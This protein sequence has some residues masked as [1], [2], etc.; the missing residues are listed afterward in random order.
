[1]VKPAI[2]IAEDDESNMTYFN[3]ILKD[4][5]LTIIPAIN[6][7][8]AVECCHDHPEIS[9]VLMDMKMPVMDGMEATREIKKIRKDI[10]I[11]AV[12]AFTL[13]GD[14]KRAR[15]AGCDD[16]LSKPVDKTVLFAKLKKYG[17]RS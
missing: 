10:S 8:E 11:I 12:T 14:E 5:G 2:L 15:D 16:Y 4:A 1:M 6:G 7:K 13:S 9:L 3:V 17:I